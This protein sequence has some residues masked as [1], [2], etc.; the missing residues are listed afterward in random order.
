MFSFPKK[1]KAISTIEEA[2]KEIEDLK[3]K[4]QELSLEIEKIKKEES[5]NKIGLV[6]YNPF[7]ERG[8]DQSFSLAVLNNSNNGFVIT[9]IY[10]QDKSRVFSKAIT[11]GQ[12]QY[13]LSK[14]EIEAISIAK[15]KI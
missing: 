12:S 2:S 7:N 13:Q 4:L 11:N 10:S 8:G 3:G 6:R 5:L 1:E 15:Q 14:E 9:S